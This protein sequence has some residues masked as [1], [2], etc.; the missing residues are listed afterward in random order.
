MQDVIIVGGS[1]AG[2]TAAMQ[3]G[4]ARRKV[5][6][7]DTGLNRNRY[8]AHAHNILGHDG[9]PPGDLL[10]R[11]R[12][13]VEHYPTV[14]LVQ[15]KA[16]AIAGEPDNFAIT[17]EDGASLEGRR[18][19]LAYG[20]VDHFPAIPGFAECWGKTVIHCPFCHGYE[21]AGQRWG[22]VY[23]SP[24]SLHGPVLYA[25]WTDDITLFLDGHE[26][27]EQERSKLDKRGVKII[28]AKLKSIRHDNGQL[29]SV[30][31][32]D[33]QQVELEALYAHPRNHPSADLHAQ[34]GL[35]MTETPTG[36]MIAV[37]DMQATSRPGIYAAGDLTTAMHSVTFASN[38]GSM[39]AMGVLQSMMG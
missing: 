22:L 7:L 29:H 39:A 35:D 4:R 34:L 25:N 12:A 2:L 6:V 33:G 37:G 26:I 15:G 36:T 30:A 13:Q 8:A 24:M 5:S 3:L 28:D 32:E 16:I 19:I 38:S 11:A 10:A 18:V 17:T 14:Q 9:T 27:I 31:T 1:F 20:I 21:V 23:S